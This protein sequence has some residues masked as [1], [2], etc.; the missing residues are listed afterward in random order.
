MSFPSFHLIKI[1]LLGWGLIS[2]FTSR[3]F[4]FTWIASWIYFRSQR[5]PIK[6]K[7]VRE[8]IPNY[9][10]SC[11]TPLNFTAFFFI[12]VALSGKRLNEDNIQWYVLTPEKNRNGMDCVPDI[13]IYLLRLW[14]I[15][16]NWSHHSGE[17]YSHVQIIDYLWYLHRHD[18]K[19]SKLF[20]VL[21][22]IQIVDEK[23]EIKEYK[24]WLILLKGIQPW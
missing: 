23:S 14:W 20:E 12:P 1:T 17:N 9:T 11:L 5:K 16:I 4:G 15:V 6:L 2:F 24:L 8:E 13:S 18:E 19:F 3:V 10:N 22:K 21:F 7:T